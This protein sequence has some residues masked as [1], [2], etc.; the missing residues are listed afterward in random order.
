MGGHLFVYVREPKVEVGFAEDYE[1]D[2][3]LNSLVLVAVEVGEEV[4]YL[5]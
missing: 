4:Q 1:K 2:V 5:E 3:K